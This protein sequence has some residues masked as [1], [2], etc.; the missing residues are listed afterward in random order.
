MIAYEFDVK[1]GTLPQEHGYHLLAGLS[2]HYP[3]LH[4]RADLQ[5]APVW[6]DRGKDNR[7]TL[8]DRSR[9]HIRGL[10]REEAERMQ[11]GWASV[12]GTMIFW[13]GYHTRYLRPA[14]SLVSRCVVFKGVTSA[15]DCESRVKQA[16][17]EATVTVG[18]HRFVPVKGVHHK[19]FVVRLDGLADAD[20]MRLQQNGF[21]AHTSF[22]CGIF[23][24]VRT[25][26]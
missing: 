17:P 19:G 5:I 11:N 2:Q 25:G 4:G 13:Q 24:P 21:G 26:R 10:T 9:L 16:F 1:G 3:F 22:G 14:A 6:G 8:G 15:K 23:A 18:R 7:L 20:S 12:G